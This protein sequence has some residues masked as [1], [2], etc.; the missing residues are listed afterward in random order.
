MNRRFEA[1]DAFRGICAISVVIFHMHFVNSIT[2]LDFFRG[3]ALFVQFFFVL[4]GFVLANGYSTKENM[5]FKT[6]M[7]A[8]FYRI[9]PLHICMLIVFIVFETCK[10]IAYKFI[11]I[12]FNGLPFTNSTAITEIL[13]NLLLIQSWSHFT[14]P[15]SFNYPSWSISIEFYLY[16]LLF[17]TIVTFKSKKNLAWLCISILAFLLIYFKSDMLVKTALKGLFCFF[18]GAAAYLL[19]NKMSHIRFTFKFASLVEVLIFILIYLVISSNFENRHLIAPILFIFTVLFFSFE[20]GFISKILKIKLFQAVGKLSY[21]IYMTH[22]AILFCLTSM[23]LIFQKVTGKS[24]APM[25]DS[26]RYLNL[27]EPLVNNGL[28][29]I[30]LIVIIYISRITYNNIE[31]KG[32]ALNKK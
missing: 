25:I 30:T 14:D 17:F 16:A 29:L 24:V 23:A 10:L 5:S 21:S 8:R 12:S 32:L 6:F 11:G 7:K 13:P 19:F 26:Q 20:A 27:G 4:S 18:S 15:L 22:A 2:E 31:L 9:Y 1:L 3:S 28:I